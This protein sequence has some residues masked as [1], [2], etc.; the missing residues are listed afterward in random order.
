MKP[1]DFDILYR[2]FEAP[3]SKFD[4]GRFCSPL[5]KGSPVCCSVEHAIPVVQKAEWHLLRERT[6]LWS[7]FK[8]FDKAS[9]DIVDELA[10]DCAA[11]ECKGA[12]F[13]ERENRTL[14]CRSFPFFPYIDRNDALIGVSYYWDFE[15][16]CWVISNLQ[17]VDRAFIDEFIAA[18]EMLFDKD[19][20][21]FDSYRDQS[22]SMRRVFSRWRRPIPIIGRDGGYLKELPRGRGLVPAK[23]SEFRRLGPF[24]SPEAFRREVRELQGRI[25]HDF[26]WKSAF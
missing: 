3:I 20:E 15:D 14:A 9:K 25:P 16:R 12:R 22:I 21:E 8:P 13:C 10:D 1:A 5:N 19:P 17:K 11:I 23:A 7:K 4:C 2:N 18:Y 6:D 26:D 24:K